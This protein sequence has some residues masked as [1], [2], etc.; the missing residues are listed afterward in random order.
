[1]TCLIARLATGLVMGTFGAW[2]LLAPSQWTEYVP[3]IPA[4]R[5]E[6][7]PLVLAHGWILFVLAAAAWI[8]FL[9]GVT[10]WLAV[11]MLTEVV[12]GLLWGT[13]IS[14]TIIRDVGVL[15]LALVWAL[16]ETGD[17]DPW[18]QT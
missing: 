1:M 16:E 10:A 8:N 2:E 9:P 14:A 13:G 18:R 5:L 6:A 4:A 12:A 15:A 11:A 3:P 17:R 7:V